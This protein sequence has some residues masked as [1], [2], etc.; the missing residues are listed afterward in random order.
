MRNIN[1][2]FLITNLVVV[3]KYK[4]KYYNHCKEKLLKLFNKY[5]TKQSYKNKKQN[6]YK[7]K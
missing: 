7:N 2:N 6:H 3:N 5:K 1:C 4:P